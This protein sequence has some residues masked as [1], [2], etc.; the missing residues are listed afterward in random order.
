MMQFIVIAILLVVLIFN[1]NFN[2]VHVTEFSGEHE[3]NY[4]TELLQ[5]QLVN[6]KFDGNKVLV[7][8]VDL[9]TAVELIEL[10]D[11]NSWSSVFADTSFTMTTD[12]RD[13]QFNT[14]IKKVIEKS[15]VEIDWIEEADVRLYESL[16]EKDNSETFNGKNKVM[17]LVLNIKEGVSL[18]DEM[19]KG[20][21]SLMSNSIENLSKNEVLI[22]DY[23]GIVLYERLD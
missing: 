23:Q 1:E 19:I 15:L 6:F 20:I 8:E 12:D 2:M 5:S 13:T 7:S 10:N 3:K 14:A 17:I 9:H 4:Y 22:F 16:I 21:A 11:K 18:T